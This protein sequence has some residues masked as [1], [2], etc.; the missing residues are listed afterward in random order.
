MGSDPLKTRKEEEEEE[1]K[2]TPNEPKKDK[3]PKEME[4]KISIIQMSSTRLK[5]NQMNW[6]ITEIELLAILWSLEHS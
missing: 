3:K 6:S 5:P 1:E 4:K 2:Q